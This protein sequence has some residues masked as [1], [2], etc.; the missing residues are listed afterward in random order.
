MHATETLYLSKFCLKDSIEWNI[1]RFQLDGKGKIH[2]GEGGA[3]S[4]G[5]LPFR[6]HGRW[7][8]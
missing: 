8:A 3:P 5:V 6:M 4:L 2:P 7:Q 1:Y